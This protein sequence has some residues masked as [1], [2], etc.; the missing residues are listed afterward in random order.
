[1]AGAGA[2]GWHAPVAQAEG[3][4]QGEGLRA[5]DLLGTA[6]WTGTT[7]DDALGPMRATG[8]PSRWNPCTKVNSLNAYH[9]PTTY[10]LERDLLT[11]QSVHLMDWKRERRE[12]SIY[13]LPTR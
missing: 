12:G 11:N 7:A 2:A 13:Y 3:W 6:R 8:K 9:L 4:H 1:M 10:L 5:A